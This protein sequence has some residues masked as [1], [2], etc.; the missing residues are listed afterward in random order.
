MIPSI[1]PPVIETLFEFCV[2]IVPNPRVVLAADA[3]A[4]STSDL[5]NEVNVASAAVPEPVKYG[6]LSAAD[7]SPAMAASSASYA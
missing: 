4:S 5:P 2:A 1:D 7:V 3:S 6:S